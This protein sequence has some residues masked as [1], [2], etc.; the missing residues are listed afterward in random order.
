[1]PAGR[2]HFSRGLVADY[3]LKQGEYFKYAL[4]LEQPR[5][6][7][8][9]KGDGHDRYHQDDEELSLT[10]FPSFFTLFSSCQY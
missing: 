2:E 7:C 8:R 9:Q 6:G 1:M 3:L 5:E 10:L 4:D